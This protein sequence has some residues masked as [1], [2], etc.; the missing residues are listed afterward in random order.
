MSKVTEDVPD[1]YDD[2]PKPLLYHA[3]DTINDR[4][5]DT[6]EVRK[7]GWRRIVLFGLFFTPSAIYIKDA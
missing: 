3:R 4:V 6:Y 5:E 7:R 2:D 1:I